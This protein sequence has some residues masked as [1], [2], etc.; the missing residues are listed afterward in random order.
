MG[1]LDMFGGNQRIISHLS[2]WYHQT[3]EY[4]APGA[5]SL[6]LTLIDVNS[7]IDQEEA[8][9]IAQDQEKAKFY[10]PFEEGL[11]GDLE[12]VKKKAEAIVSVFS[13]IGQFGL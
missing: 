12:I 10:V 9:L 4:Y 8:V 3:G 6:L 5:E 1:A 2:N 13:K 11:E 7:M